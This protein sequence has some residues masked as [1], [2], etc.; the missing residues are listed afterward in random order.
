MKLKTNRKE[1]M[2]RSDRQKD[3]WIRND[4]CALVWSGGCWLGYRE[5]KP[6]RWERNSVEFPKGGG[7]LFVGNRFQRM[8][9]FKSPLSTASILLLVG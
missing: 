7:N 1:I 6:S 3:P 4:K 9:A 8:M 5:E 2:T